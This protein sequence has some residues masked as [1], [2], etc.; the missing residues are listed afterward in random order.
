MRA[1]EQFDRQRCPS[2][3]LSDPHAHLALGHEYGPIAGVPVRA[4]LRTQ[5]SA[6]AVA[7]GQRAESGQVLVGDTL[8]LGP[9]QAGDAT[10]QIGRSVAI[11]C[12]ISPRSHGPEANAERPGAWAAIGVITDRTAQPVAPAR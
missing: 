2:T 12:G 8:C 9:S 1:S 5:Q 3:V 10:G 7:D 4:R 11:Y 6:S